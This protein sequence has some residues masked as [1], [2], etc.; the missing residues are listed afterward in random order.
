MSKKVHPKGVEM[1]Q[2]E[3]VKFMK[4]PFDNVYMSPKAQ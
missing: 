4:T 2:D 1:F 3:I